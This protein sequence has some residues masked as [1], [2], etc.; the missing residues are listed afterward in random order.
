MSPTRAQ[1]EEYESLLKSRS[2]YK[3]KA[4]TGFKNLDEKL[5]SY[6]QGSPTNFLEVFLSKY[7]NMFEKYEEA[8][9]K[10]TLH[11]CFEASD[12]DDDLEQYLED[13]LNMES[14]VTEHK[15]E[16]EE[17][18]R[19]AA[20]NAANPVNPPNQQPG[21]AGSRSPK[22]EISKPPQLKEDLDILKFIKWKPLWSNYVKLTDMGKLSRETQVAIFWQ[23][24]SPGFLN[25]VQHSLGIKPDTTKTVDEI[26]KAIEKHLRSLRSIHNDLLVLLGTRQKTG[27]NITHL[28]N[29][30]LEKAS[31]AD[32]EHITQD[33]LMIA[34]LL[35]AL[36]SE[37]MK[38]ELLKLRP[39]TFE[40][41]R[42]F[43][44]ELE[45]AKRTAH[46]MANKNVA[47]VNKNNGIS[48]YKRDQ[49]EGHNNGNKEDQKNKPKCSTCKKIFTPVLLPGGKPVKTCT[50]CYN[51]RL[52]KKPK[53][54]SGNDTNRMGSIT[55]AS[56]TEG[57]SKQKLL[58]VNFK[59]NSNNSLQIFC[60]PDTGAETIVM[61]HQDFMDQNLD[62][63]VKLFQD[64]PLSIHG[65]KGK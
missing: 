18:R 54:K 50:P 17:A 48:Q 9:Q 58:L 13:Y 62:K 27:Q 41:S 38:S 29:E 65:I 51:Q 60:C 8:D 24:C 53:P 40:E 21:A 64:K 31:Y 61:G 47:Y 7:S 57:S 63:Y 37:E 12:K 22:I 32:T 23:N 59:I 1:T 46:S 14:V 49:K 56:A 6:N 36:D 15:R 25:T 19:T 5:Q 45:T 28:C 2:S 4:R 43:L 39:K 20:A 44:L 26:H 42:T 55:I 10:V 16:V 33:L 30:L 35:Q 3:G 11:T 52:N 34:I